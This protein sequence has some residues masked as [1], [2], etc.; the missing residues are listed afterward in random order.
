MVKHGLKYYAATGRVKDEGRWHV[1]CAALRT[2][3]AGLASPAIS[4]RA[5]VALETRVE[6]GCVGRER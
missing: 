2:T 6:R 3:N 4:A 5:T 1:N